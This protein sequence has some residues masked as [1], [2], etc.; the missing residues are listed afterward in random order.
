LSL[1][2]L[3]QFTVVVGVELLETLGLSFSA[4]ALDVRFPCRLFAVA[5][6]TV[7]VTSYFLRIAGG[8][9]FA[10]SFSETS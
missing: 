9:D 1:L 2:A 3:V 7:P 10:L 4:S 6:Q 5:Q 8:N